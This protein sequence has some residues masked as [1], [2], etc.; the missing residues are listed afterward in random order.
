MS[1]NEQVW[2]W[3]PAVR[4]NTC[5][6]HPNPTLVTT[7]I[8]EHAPNFGGTPTQHWWTGRSIRTRSQHQHCILPLTNPTL[9][10]SDVWEHA[11]NFWTDHATRFELQ[12]VRQ[13]QFDSKIEVKKLL[14]DQKHKT[15]FVARYVS[16]N[17]K[18]SAQ[19]HVV[20]TISR[21]RI[22]QQI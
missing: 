20:L 8:S 3:T 2:G 22:W 19:I 4:T 5:D 13:S 21:W 1:G 6:C 15:A 12:F 7:D 10:T 17:H 16:K 18:F 14:G 9:V 11:T